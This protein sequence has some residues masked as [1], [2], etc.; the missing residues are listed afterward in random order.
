M[1]TNETLAPTEQAT[2]ERLTWIR[3]RDAVRRLGF[4]SHWA[5]MS[6]LEAGRLPIRTTRLGD[7]GIVF[8]CE[9]DVSA[10]AQWLA[11]GAPE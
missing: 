1:T 3:L 6:D 5:L 7:R 4:P 10:Y 8:L 9:Q 2:P 11:E